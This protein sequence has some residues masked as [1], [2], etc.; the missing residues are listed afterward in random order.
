VT[1]WLLAEQV[2][3]ESQAMYRDVVESVN[4]V[5]FQADAEGR[6]TSQ[7]GMAQHHGFRYPAEHRSEPLIS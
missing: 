5:L 3:R 6:I 2:L 1:R 7:P 4:E